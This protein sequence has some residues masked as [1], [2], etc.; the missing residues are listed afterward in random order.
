MTKSVFLVS[1]GEYSDYR[2]NAIYSTWQKAREAI[3]SG[4]YRMLRS[5]EI[6]I[7]NIVWHD[8]RYATVRFQYRWEL[9]TRYAPEFT[10]DVYI[11]EMGV[12]EN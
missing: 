6:K 1:T 4:R 8:N 3:E 7:L 2:I 11:E 9:E 12:D 10:E 5:D